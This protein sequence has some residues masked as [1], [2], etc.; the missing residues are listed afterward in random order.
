MIGSYMEEHELKQLEE[1]LSH[2]VKNTMSCWIETMIN[3]A[4]ASLSCD[5]NICIPLL[6]AFD[7]ITNKIKES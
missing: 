4:G 6:K 7:T 1:L 5:G 3:G 2:S